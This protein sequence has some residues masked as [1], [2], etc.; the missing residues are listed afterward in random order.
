LTSGLTTASLAL[1]DKHLQTA[2]EDIIMTRKG[3]N[4]DIRVGGR[5]VT[6]SVDSECQ[7]SLAAACNSHADYEVLRQIGK[8]LADVLGGVWSEPSK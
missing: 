1:I 6:V 2:A 4:W 5:P 7:I 3:R 8:D